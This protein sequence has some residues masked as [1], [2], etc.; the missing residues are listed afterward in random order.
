MDFG[1]EKEDGKDGKDGK[2][3]KDNKDNKDDKGCE[4][5]EIVVDW[6]RTRRGCKKSCSQCL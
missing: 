2:D 1:G 4:R 5:R 6:Q 3:N